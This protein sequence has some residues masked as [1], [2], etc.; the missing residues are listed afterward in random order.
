[1]HPQRHRAIQYIADP[2]VRVSGVDRVDLRH[3]F[4]WGLDN[5]GLAVV[6]DQTEGKLRFHKRPIFTIVCVPLTEGAPPMSGHSK[7]STIK[8]KKGAA[9]AKRGK[10]FTRIIKEMTI[11]ARLG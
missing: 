11:A 8:H 7:W 6:E 1:M 5:N 10:V 4:F 9:D 2:D 3:Q